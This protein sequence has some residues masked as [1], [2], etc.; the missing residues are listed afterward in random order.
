[1]KL[2]RANKSG[3]YIEIMGGRMDMPPALAFA[4]AQLKAMYASRSGRWRKFT[5]VKADVGRGL[6]RRNAGHWQSIGLT[7][8]VAAPDAST[9]PRA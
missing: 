6:D 5:R 2:A 7:G 1:M 4:H 9:P 3:T 8:G